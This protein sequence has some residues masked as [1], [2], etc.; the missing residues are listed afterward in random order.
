MIRPF[1]PGDFYLLQ[2]LGRKATYLPCAHTFLQPQSSM[3][4]ALSAVLPWT[5]SKAMTYVLRQDGHGLVHEGFLQ[6]RHHGVAHEA[7]ILCMAPSLDAPSGHPAI[8]SKLLS[9]LIHEAAALGIARIYADVPDQ[10]L[11]VHTFA[12]VGFEPFCHQTIWRSFAPAQASGARSAPLLVTPRTSSDD[13]DLLRLYLGT[14]PEHVRIAEGV[15]GERNASTPLIENLH[16]EQGVIYVLRSNDAAT[17]NRVT[18]NG[19]IGAFQL[20]RGARGSWLRIWAD[21]LQPD[22]QPLRMLFT[23]AALVAAQGQW[24]TPLYFASSDFQGGLGAMLE[25]LGFAPFCDRVRMVKH[26]MKWVRESVASTAPVV[27]TTGEIVPT[28]FTSP[29]TTSPSIHSSTPVD[30]GSAV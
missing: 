6:V 14:V 2:R 11:L 19:L 24:P 7:D 1:Q 12:N 18:S 8:W 28:T 27:E 26:V 29:K 9:H 16:P 10:P 13:W 17:G 22:S 3:S 15:N 5:T 20:Q 23:Q 30:S 25:E 4:V 21:T